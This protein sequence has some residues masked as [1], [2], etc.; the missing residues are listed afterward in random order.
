MRS[1]LGRKS[2]LGPAEIV[3]Y[4]CRDF[5][6]SNKH[7]TVW[8]VVSTRYFYVL[9]TIAASDFRPLEIYKNIALP[10]STISFI[11][12]SHADN[13]FYKYIYLFQLLYSMKSIFFIKIRVEAFYIQIWFKC[14]TPLLFFITKTMVYRK[15]SL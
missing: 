11:V 9:W 13:H 5:R 10:L 15:N 3:S 7:D 14:E 4:S 12:N 1:C 8:H 2:Y 6:R